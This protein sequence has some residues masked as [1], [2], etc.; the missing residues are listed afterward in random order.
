[1]PDS[2]SFLFSLVRPS[3]DEPIKIPVL[4]GRNGGIGYQERY[5]SIFTSKS[6]TDLNVYQKDAGD[7]VCHHNLGGCF[8][9]PEGDGRN[10]TFLTVKNP[11]EITEMEVFKIDLKVPMK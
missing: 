5:G 3:G 7:L 1:M 8:M 6:L 9:N 10:D 4:T 2:R 11:S